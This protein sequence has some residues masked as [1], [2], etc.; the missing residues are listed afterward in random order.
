MKKKIQ[1]AKEYILRLPL[2][3]KII[4]W[5]KTYAPPGF[6]RVPLYH[7]IL[8][9]L[10]EAKEDKLTTRAN[11]VAYS[12]F[13]AIFPGILFLFTLLPLIPIVQD[14]TSMLDRNSQNLLPA[15][16]HDYL[17]G[18]IRDITSIKREGL[19]S[20]GVF[21]ALFFSSN[22]MLTLMSG[23]DKSYE[24][25][26]LRRSYIKKRLIALALTLVLSLL[27]IVVLVV[28]VLGDQI[29]QW[30]DNQFNIPVTLLFLTS[31]LLR[32]ILGIS[33]IYT[34]ISLIYRY[35]PSMHR[36]TQF[37]NLGAM[38]ATFLFIGVTFIFSFAINKFGRYNELYGSI[39]A[40]IVTMVWF[41]I[42]AFILLVG[43]ELN[44][45]IAVNKDILF[46]EKNINPL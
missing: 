5:S 4:F 44:A 9:I 1:N 32:W 37:I 18:I 6:G 2:I 34:G 8:F 19:L 39:G 20:L 33:V 3:S 22:G 27:F 21:L 38:M 12:L 15:T 46:P 30:V 7:V 35:G 23:F 17:F 28:L 36:R 11:S 14:Y 24:Y 10:K 16:T 43:F 42:N 25:T 40:L 13:L 31:T 41:Q 29:L 45:S 26:F